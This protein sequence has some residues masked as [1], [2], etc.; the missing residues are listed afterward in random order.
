MSLH[1]QSAVNATVTQTLVA[2]KRISAK[3][4]NTNILEAG[5]VRAEIFTVVEAPNVVDTVGPVTGDGTAEDPVTLESS[6]VIYEWLGQLAIQQDISTTLYWEDTIGTFA[7]FDLAGFPTTRFVA[8]NDLSA[9]EL[10]F[11]KQSGVDMGTLTLG[12]VD[13]TNTVIPGAAELPLP[14]LSAN[15]TGSHG[16][17]RYN[18]TT[19]L[20][21]GTPF[22]ISATSSL[23]GAPRIRVLANGVVAL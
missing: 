19:T 18:F 4:I 22:C 23:A 11:T 15:P 16:I 3:Q 20:P 5:E 13:T 14:L 17:A 7:T 21:A 1:D 12:I 10:N 2:N 8:L 9:V 6:A